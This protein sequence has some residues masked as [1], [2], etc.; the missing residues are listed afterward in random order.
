[1]FFWI[2]VSVCLFL[3]GIVKDKSKFAEAGILL[4]LFVAMAFNKD[5]YDY[6]NYVTHYYEFVNG[7]NLLLSFSDNL[8]LL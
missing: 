6:N 2:G 1:M 5:T 8:L 4:F 3:W 7:I